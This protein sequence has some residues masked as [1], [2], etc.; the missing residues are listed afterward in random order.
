MFNLSSQL[1]G[2]SELI[3][4]LPLFDGGAV[5]SV[6]SSSPGILLCSYN[7]VLLGVPIGLACF[8]SLDGSGPC[9]SSVT[10]GGHSVDTIFLFA[11]ADRSYGDICV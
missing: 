11:R 9:F 4:L 1:V 8:C 2:K 7:V 10:K 3:W 6:F 5:V